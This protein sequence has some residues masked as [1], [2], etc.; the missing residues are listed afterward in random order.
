MDRDAHRVNG[1]MELA[2]N[3]ELPYFSIGTLARFLDLAP[4]T[5]LSLVKKG[6]IPA[7]RVDGWLRFDKKKIDRWLMERG[8]DSSGRFE[9]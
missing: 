7:Q 9:L 5:I 3:Y 1:L 2:E 4:E 8:R 6:D